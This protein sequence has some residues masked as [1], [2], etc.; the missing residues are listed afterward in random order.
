[1][2]YTH[3]HIHIL[4]MGNVQNIIKTIF[5]IYYIIEKFLFS[6]NSGDLLLLLQIYFL[7]IYLLFKMVSRLLSFIIF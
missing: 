3:T 5:A 1:M 4:I 7:I 6:I 2:T